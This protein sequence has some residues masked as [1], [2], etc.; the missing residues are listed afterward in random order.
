LRHLQHWS[1]YMIV[2]DTERRIHISNYTSYSILGETGV[3]HGYT[4]GG[5]LVILRIH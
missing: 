3:L 4:V 5:T 1:V 2:E